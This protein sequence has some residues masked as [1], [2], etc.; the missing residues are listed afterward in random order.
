[1]I[2]ANDIDRHSV[3]TLA[4]DH[5]LRVPDDEVRVGFHSGRGVCICRACEVAW[6]FIGK[7]GHR[8]VFRK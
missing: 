2:H 5:P 3:F 7:L 8:P 6:T 1:M 4:A